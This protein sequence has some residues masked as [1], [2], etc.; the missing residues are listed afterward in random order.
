M[1]FLRFEWLVAP[2]HAAWVR[3]GAGVG[4][5]GGMLAFIVLLWWFGAWPWPS[6]P[7]DG[8][9]FGYAAMLLGFP[10]SLFAL[11]FTPLGPIAA[12]FAIGASIVLSWGVLG[13]VVAGVASMVYH[14][15]RDR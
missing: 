6:N 5:A 10:L 8:E 7:Y 1:S 3:A 15:V 4:S 9:A 13:G 14:R 11:S 12:L 2:R